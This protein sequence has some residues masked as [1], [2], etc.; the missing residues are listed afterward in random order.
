MGAA[1]EGS[2]ALPDILERLADLLERQ[3][4]VRGKL[5]AALVYPAALAL[6]A[7]AVVNALMAFVVPKVVDQFDSMGRVL[8]ALTQVLIAQY[9]LITIWGLHTMGPHR[10]RD[11]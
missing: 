2:G 9:E 5:V 7:L 11:A 4:Q 3:Q 8:P 1:G 6:T 10:K